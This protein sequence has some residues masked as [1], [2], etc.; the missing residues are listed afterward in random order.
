MKPEIYATKKAIALITIAMVK[1][2]GIEDISFEHIVS[3]LLLKGV[4]EDTF[5]CLPSG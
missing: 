4:S 3:V 5:Q 2:I 1:M